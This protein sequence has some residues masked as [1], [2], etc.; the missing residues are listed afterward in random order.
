M[1]FWFHVQV[2]TLWHDPKN[3]G[4]KDY[5]AYRWHLTHRPKTG[6]I[7]YAQTESASSPAS[8]LTIYHT[9]RFGS[10]DLNALLSPPSPQG[11][12]V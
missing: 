9:M 6:L 2:R 5:T 10:S 4:W 8:I 1:V 3:I 11:G 7:R 12:H